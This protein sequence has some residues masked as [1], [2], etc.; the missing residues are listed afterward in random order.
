M[1][2]PFVRQGALQRGDVRSDPNMINY[3]CNYLLEGMVVGI[4]YPGDKDARRK[5]EISYD[6][7]PTSIMLP[8]IRYAVRVDVAAGIDDGDDNILRVATDNVQKGVSVNLT[9]EVS[10]VVYTPRQDLD[11]DRVLVGF[12][13]GS[14]TRPVIVGVLPHFKNRRGLKDA[15]GKDFP[16]KN[17]LYR[18]WSHRGTEVVTDSQ[19][20]IKVV[21]AKVPDDKKSDKKKLTLVIGDL[22]VTIDNSN[23]EPAELRIAN[24][25]ESTTFFSL[26]DKKIVIKCDQADVTTTGDTSI[27]ASGSMSV[28]SSGDATIRS[29]G[30]VNI[31]GS[32]KV[33]VGP[34]SVVLAG[35]TNG[36][37]TATSLS[38]GCVSGQA[39]PYTL[40]KGAIDTATLS[41]KVKAG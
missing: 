29:D 1:V 13:N 30:T 33:N 16:K 10:G 24:K 9:G 14:W 11:G 31:N 15:T 4:H 25:D 26:K 38:P 18:R 2:A 39:G 6:V 22:V 3:R 8:K 21:F 27:S 17:D 37:V 40:I 35:G 32:S 34:D 12:V 36:V 23:G 41:S 19:G 5:N 7:Q 20:N 28:A